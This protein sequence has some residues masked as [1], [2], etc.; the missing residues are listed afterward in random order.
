ML[1][2]SLIPTFYTTGQLETQAGLYKDGNTSFDEAKRWQDTKNIC[3]GIS[4]GCGV[5]MAY[6]L[7]RYLLAANSVLPQTV[8]AGNLNEYEYYD[9]SKAREAEE[10]AGEEVSKSENKE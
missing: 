7:V 6:E 10:P 2:V 9:F 1:I 4:I 3:T 8:S 5:F